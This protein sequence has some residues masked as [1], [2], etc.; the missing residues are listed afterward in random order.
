MFIEDSDDAD[1]NAHFLL[2]S[3]L[4]AACIN[5]L[6]LPRLTKVQKNV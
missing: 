1:K 3:R 4:T 2:C 6:Q 5:D